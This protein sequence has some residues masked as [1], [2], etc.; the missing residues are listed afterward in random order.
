MRFRT[1][2]AIL[3]GAVAIGLAATLFALA[4]DAAGGLFERFV[5]A[6]PYAPLLVTPLLFAGLVW[7]TRRHVPL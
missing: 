6:Y 3:L 1:R 2:L 5:R 4:A 7:L